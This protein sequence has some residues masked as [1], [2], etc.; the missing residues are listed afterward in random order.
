MFL[1]G[2]F[3]PEKDK[4]DKQIYN[5]TCTLLAGLT[6][7]RNRVIN[8]DYKGREQHPIDE[9]SANIASSIHVLLNVS[10]LRE[11][12]EGNAEY[13][14]LL[15][16]ITGLHDDLLI[17]PITASLLQENIARIRSLGIFKKVPMDKVIPDYE[18]YTGQ[19]LL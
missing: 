12:A 2:F 18:E 5:N 8:N 6:W 4:A 3:R 11:R 15:A 10:I 13:D 19:E 1:M 9:S 14:E 7:A 17:Q 16:A